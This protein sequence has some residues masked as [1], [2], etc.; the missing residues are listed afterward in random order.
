M[1]K[2]FLTSFL[3]LLFSLVGQAQSCLP[4]G[5][6]LTTQAQV[7][8][9]PLNYPGC[10][11]IE[12]NLIIQEN[13]SA[14]TITNLD[15]LSNIT[16]VSGNLALYS[17]SYLT[18]L[19]GLHNITSV[20]GQLIIYEGHGLTDL[21]GLDNLV[22]VGAYLNISVC[23]NLINLGGAGNLASVYG[24][25]ISNCDNL[26]DLSGMENLTSL[27]GLILTENDALVSLNG[28]PGLDTLASI[29]NI[30]QN[31]FLT[32]LTALEG[33]RVVGGDVTIEY[34][35]SLSNLAG[36]D[37]LI[38]I[39]GNLSFYFDP[40]LNSLEGLNNLHYIG[41]NFHVPPVAS[42]SGLIGLD[43]IGNDFSM[44]QIGATNLAGLDNLKYIGG[45][46]SIYQCDYLTDL[47]GLG[48]LAAC[49]KGVY[50]GNN[51]QMTSLSGLTKLR[52]LGLELV[53]TQNPS[54]IDLHG[55]DSLNTISGY[56]QIDQNAVLE[57]LDGLENLL[58]V[59]ES[60]SV[61]NNPA[62]SNCAIFAICD[63]LQTNPG[64]VTIQNNAPGCNSLSEIQP[65]C[66][67]VPFV[68]VMVLAD[69]NG[70]CLP[71]VA[72][73]PVAGVQVQLQGDTLVKVM[74]TGIDG[75]ALFKYPENSAGTVSLTQFP[76]QN[77]AV[78]QQPVTIMPGQ[79]Q[80]T[81][82]A[83]LLLSPLNLCPE[84]TVE[85]G[86]PSAFYD[87]SVNST[88]A[89]STQN[90]GTALAENV[91][92][93]I[94]M[95]PV[96]ELLAAV[97]PLAGQSGD[98]L[99]FE[100]ED[101][102]PL[103]KTGVQLTVK[104]NCD[105]V[106]TGHAVCW[107]SFASLDNPCPTSPPAAS[108]IS[109]SAQCVGD[110][111]IR[112]NVKNIG[113]A[114]T[115]SL[116][117]YFLIKNAILL[118]TAAFSL[119]PQESM[120]VDVPATGATYRMEATKFNDGTLTS[121]SEE[122]CGGFVPG[123]VTAFWQ[124]KG[125]RDYDSGC[126][127]VLANTI[128]NQKTA[129]PTG[130]GFSY[131]VAANRPVQYTIDFQNTGG[132]TVH[133][134]R[135]REFL[136][137]HLALNTFRPS[138]ASH[139][140]SWEI[141]GDN[142]LEVFFDNID[143]PTS[144]MN[145]AA[146][147]G[148]FTF[149][150]DQNPDLADGAFIENRAFVY[151]DLDPAIL[152][153]AANTVGHLSGQ[154]SPCVLGDIYLNSQAQV[155]GF[156]SSYPGCEVVEGSIFIA[157]QDITN[158]NGMLGLTELTGYLSIQNCPNLQNLN[159]LDNLI[160]V[161][162]FYLSSNYGIKN[163]HGLGNLMTVSGDFDISFNDSL[164]TFGSLNKLTSV[165]GYLSVRNNNQLEHFD[166]MDQLQSV[167]AYLNIANNPKLT[168]LDGLDQLVSVDDSIFVGNNL[169][170]SQL[171]GFQSLDS[172][173][174]SF[175]IQNNAALASLNELD[176]LH[177]V[178]KN[179]I[180]KSNAALADLGSLQ[181][182]A[183]VGDDL[184]INQNPVLG[185][186]DGLKNLVTV[187]NTFEIGFNENL[188]DINGFDSLNFVGNWFDITSNNILTDIGGFGNLT[189]VGGL[190]EIRYH[191]N[192]ASISGFNK[193]AEV[194]GGMRLRQNFAT[195]TLD[196]F[197]SLASIGGELWIQDNQAMTSISG[198][199]QLAS[200]GGDFLVQKNY[201]VEGLGGFPNLTSVAGNMSLDENYGLDTISAFGN[202]DTIAG[203]FNLTYNGALT[204]LDNFNSLHYV[205]GNLLVEQCNSL[206]NLI[207]LDSLTNI[208]GVLMLNLNAQ[209]ESLEGLNNLLH[210]GNV[211]LNSNQVLLDLDGLQNLAAVPGTISIFNNASLSNCSAFFLCERLQMPQ[212]SAN[213]Y[214]NAAG[215]NSEQEVLALCGGLQI[216]ALVLTDEN[217]DCLPDAADIPV[218]EV[219]V[220]MDN[221]NQISIRPTDA[222]GSCHFGY[223]SSLESPL[224]LPQFPTNYW[225]TCS[226][227]TTLLSAAGP[228]TLLT[229][230]LLSSTDPCPE[231]EV[232]LGLPANFRNCFVNSEVNVS[233]KNIGNISAE[234]VELALVVPSVVEVLDA[235]PPFV[236]QNG[237]TLFFELGD[238]PPL[239]VTDVLLTVKTSCDTFLIDQTL[240]WEAF[241]STENPCPDNSSPHSEIKLSTQCLGD[242][243]VRFTLENIGDAATLN[244][245][246]YTIIQNESIFQT[247]NFTLDSQQSTTVDVPANGATYRME[248]T[249]FDDGTLTAIAIENCGGLTP[250]LIT[251]FWL[252]E[253]PL[254]YDFSCRQVI[255]SFDP[256][257]KTAVPSGVDE[258]HIIEANRP[259]QYTI[260]FQNT[261]TDTAFRVLLRDILPPNLDVNTFRPGFASHP[262]TW[263]IKGMDTLEVLFFP[264][265]LPDSNVNEPASHGFFSFNINQI[266]A[267]S[268][269][270][271]I[272]NMASIIFDFNPPITTNL[273]WHTIGQLLIVK[274]DEPQ[275]Q[276]PKWQVLGNPT[277]D[278]AIFQST[279]DI[280][281]IKRFEL[282]DTSGRRF[283]SAQFEGQQF[284]FQR[285]G[286]PAGFYFFVI[287]D[288]QGRICTGKI[289]VTE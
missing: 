23:P 72:D 183:S 73:T 174:G 51:A 253:G 247:S 146:S 89:V 278:R 32:D 48:K 20:G 163:F 173:G 272:E 281:G 26:V 153:Y 139:P 145:E 239:T 236:A 267:L 33:L 16:S 85:L 243:I 59:G 122:G 222:D 245:H 10:T 157:G 152:T 65:L 31:P 66:T 194:G 19:H 7:N 62:L 235:N 86:L 248:A 137:Q 189:E 117:E 232:K 150:M 83:T 103:A 18:N 111:L 216:V 225:S 205:G 29:L 201:V 180:I 45:Y 13:L 276:P 286:L 27:G 138:F 260:D 9:F 195:A 135:I 193:L 178:G 78:C 179:F 52:S 277:N 15:G 199:D 5:I 274:V 154:N 252:D 269:G 140:Y 38:H 218:A 61:E 54:L 39:G 49:G 204:G 43:T 149:E 263:E 217:G 162:T 271:I 258:E 14:G 285:N 30:S 81:I 143:L 196:G 128:V 259:F 101:L 75:S 228:D 106:L 95:P 266:P 210:T 77:W 164:Q 79:Q 4:N 280:D 8:A 187:G 264:I 76:T 270:S 176:N 147:H 244:Q 91:K 265:M 90:T 221:A 120:T 57:S 160:S 240:C 67:S 116:H 229:T 214:N 246:S 182:L 207:G 21:N 110:T 256:N 68:K 172:V 279:Q 47:A 168:Q 141:S 130:V 224:Y 36:F 25:S 133:Q 250:G 104:T 121:V 92:I 28:L 254:N 159:G 60:I 127:Q 46:A 251:A 238:I 186:L 22:S 102:S 185:H 175:L 63:N 50:I 94:V 148:F 12:G 255:G 220:R 11:A 142:V 82:M 125:D 119:N 223:F 200:I 261:G 129:F 171:N 113:N 24:L 275:T 209:L 70:D 208:Q 166:G 257:Q 118:D 3:A 170:L 93:G 69:N 80:D 88:V 58:V 203:N 273:V 177:S 192:L 74:E 131:T 44:S 198:F 34:S 6:T 288:A 234:G 237:D 115:Q 132:D 184:L 2:T 151:F 97:P 219:V 191:F 190:F 188:L 212:G 109:L 124:E 112:F 99:F 134:V 268:E 165:G 42:L 56:L 37:S 233:T 55:L 53:I 181:G 136:P 123:W 206:K 71:D 211:L 241:A 98:T 262:Y 105:T 242:S 64:N 287:A 249:K 289:V 167:M 282:Y 227:L 155:D 84:L 1:K 158:L 197:E 35:N 231:L 87:C 161:G 108:E 100:M 283:R 107:E 17:N 144:S 114:A 156:S 126:R 40:S 213:I 96:F 226:P 215:C 169:I 230:F 284:E 202:L 41:G